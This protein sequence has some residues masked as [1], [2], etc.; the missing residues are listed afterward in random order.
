[1]VAPVVAENQ[2]LPLVLDLL[3]LARLGSAE[4]VPVEG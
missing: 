1:M 4:G 3:A 2:Q